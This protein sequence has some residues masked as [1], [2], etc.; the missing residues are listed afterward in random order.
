MGNKILAVLALALLLA[1]ASAL[2]QSVTYSPVIPIGIGF[3]PL[4]IVPVSVGSPVFASGDSLWVRSY[5][6]SSLL[7]LSLLAPNGTLTPSAYLGPG[8]LVSLYTFGVGDSPGQWTLEATV[9]STGESSNTTVTLQAP[10]QGLTPAFSGATLSNNNLALGFD[11][12]PTPAYNI[13]A[14]SVGPLVNTT[15][16]FRFPASLGGSMVV[17]VSGNNVSVRTSPALSP[18][19]FW[20]ELYSLRGYYEGGSLVY[21]STLAADSG[22][23]SGGQSG[24]AQSIELNDQL[25]L[26]PGRYELLAFVNGPSGLST[27]ESQLLNT[28]SPPWIPL[29]GCTEL[30][31]VTASQFVMNTNLDGPSSTWPSFLITMFDYNGIDNF[32]ITRIPTTEARIDVRSATQDERLAGVSLSAS[33][34]GIQSWEQFASGVYIIGSAF[35][36][37]VTVGVDFEGIVQQTFSVTVASPN[38]ATTLKVPVGTVHVLTSAQGAPVANASVVATPLAGQGSDLPTFH[39]SDAGTLTLFLPPGAYNLTASSSGGTSTV[40]VTVSAG[41]SVLETIDLGSAAF[42]YVVYLAAAI[43]AVGAALNLLVWRAYFARKAAYREGRV[44]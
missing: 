23:G 1:P 33:G 31:T 15:L 27:Y 29:D 41:G 21:T 17:A 20:F 22:V 24:T 6:T 39:T 40:S 13:Q 19:S 34:Q 35:P 36:M 3:G 44:S 4:S 10:T 26:R 5:E 2:A 28:G 12:P 25:Y 30:S 14:C 42:P 43:L 18:F 9:A 32:T 7:L 38:S 16:T 37:N 11:L 8:G